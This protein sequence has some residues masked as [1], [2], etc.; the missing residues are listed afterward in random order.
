MLFSLTLF[1]FACGA[2]SEQEN[3]NTDEN[4]NTE[5]NVST[6]D[7]NKT[8]SDFDFSQCDKFLDDYEEWADEI[9]VI[10][11]EF[12]TNPTDAQNMQ[13]IT[14]AGQKLSEWGNKWITLSACAGNE[15][16]AKRMDEI[17]KKVEKAMQ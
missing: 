5:T 7:E 11:Q 17:G 15:K 1:I 16:Y 6:T 9:V 10:Y 12:K 4:E 3:S 2:D 8:N 13:K 14:E